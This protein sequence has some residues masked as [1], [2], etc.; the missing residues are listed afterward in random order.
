V[1]MCNPSAVVHSPSAATGSCGFVG[2]GGGGFSF[3]GDSAALLWKSPGS[4]VAYV[5]PAETRHAAARTM[6]SRF[7]AATLQYYGRRSS[8]APR[9]TRAKSSKE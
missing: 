7:T 8:W 3:V 2:L 1:V 9:K 5:Q 6:T 4:S